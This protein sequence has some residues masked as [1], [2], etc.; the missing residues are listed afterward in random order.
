MSKQ[1]TPPVVK[2][3]RLEPAFVSALETIARS[4][5][6]TMERLLADIKKQPGASLAAKARLYALNYYRDNSLP[7]GFA[8]SS[9]DHL[10]NA[11]AHLRNHKKR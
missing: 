10:E 11:L 3:P 6:W 9:P 7:R 5:H 2:L 4:E 8:E 1:K